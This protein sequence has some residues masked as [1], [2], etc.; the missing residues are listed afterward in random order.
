MKTILNLIRHHYAVRI[1][2]FLIVMTLI[3]GTSGCVPP[4]YNLNIS[5]TEGGSV[6]TP[7]E[8][9]FTYYEGRRVRLVARPALGYQFV[10]W[11]G[12]VATITVNAFSTTIIMNGNNFITANFGCGCG[13]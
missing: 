5:S 8:G 9:V 7:G 12:D 10:N 1:S 4:Q 3:V 11:T 6:C 2:V 13:G